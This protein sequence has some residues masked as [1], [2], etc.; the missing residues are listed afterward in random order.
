MKRLPLMPGT[1][2]FTEN[3]QL[4]VPRA[5]YPGGDEDGFPLFPA[6]CA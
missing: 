3:I 1:Q 2:N 6:C 5:G 4:R